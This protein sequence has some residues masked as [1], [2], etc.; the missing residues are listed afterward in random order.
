MT[1]VTPTSRTRTDIDMDHTIE[2]SPNGSGHEQRE[3]NVRTI[4]V[5]LAFLLLGALLACV[6]VIGVF[7]YLNDTYQPGVSARQAPVQIPP[8]PRLEVYPSEQIKDLRAHEDHILTTYAW[9]DQIGR[10]H[11]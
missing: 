5:S 11:V 10:A 4:V 1:R 6:I 2:H 8:E 3:V 7:R 9:T